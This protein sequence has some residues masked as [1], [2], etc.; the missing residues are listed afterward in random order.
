MSRQKP[1]IAGEVEITYFVL[2][3][4]DKGGHSSV[5]GKRNA[6]YELSEALVRLNKLEFPVM[7]D[8]GRR[9]YF[10]AAGARA[11]GQAA[12]AVSKMLASTPPPAASRPRS[13][14]HWSALAKAAGRL[15][16]GRPASSS[17]A[18][19]GRG[20][21]S[22]AAAS[23]ATRCSSAAAGMRQAP[24]PRARFDAV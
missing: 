23:L 5:P 21:A 11:G 17:S 10:E 12:A 15:S 3:A 19:I 13:R 18:A 9:A 16:G 20:S 7:L 8:E 14:R 4:R 24:A 2:E 6:I 22:I 1:E